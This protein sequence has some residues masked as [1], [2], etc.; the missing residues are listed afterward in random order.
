MI[1]KLKH[2]NGLHCH[3]SSKL[4]FMINFNLLS[5]LVKK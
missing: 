2:G 1:A 5:K 4:K 3:R